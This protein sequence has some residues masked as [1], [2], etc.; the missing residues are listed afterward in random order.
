VIFNIMPPNPEAINLYRYINRRIRLLPEK[1][2]RGYYH[3]HTREHFVSNR[4]ETDPSIVRAHIDKG[5][6]DC[7]WIIQKYLGRNQ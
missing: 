2:Q 7:D 4:T 3:R 1:A 5:R 6:R